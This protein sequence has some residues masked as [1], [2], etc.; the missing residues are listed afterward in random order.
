MITLEQALGV[1]IGND[2][3]DPVDHVSNERKD[4]EVVAHVGPGEHYMRG[5]ALHLHF[6]WGLADRPVDTKEFCARFH[7]LFMHVEGHCPTAGASER[8]AG[9]RPPVVKDENGA[10]LVEDVEF[11]EAPQRVTA[12]V[13]SMV[14]LRVLDRCKCLRSDQGG[15]SLA[16]PVAVKLGRFLKDWEV[17]GSG[18][19][20]GQRPPCPCD[21]IEQM[22]QRRSQLVEHVAEDDPP[23]SRWFQGV[24]GCRDY[25]LP[26]T[27]VM[28]PNRL[29]GR[30]RPVT[31]EDSVLERRC[32]AW[33]SGSRP[34]WS[35]LV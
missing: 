11:V 1:E 22:I 5:E 9:H 2:P 21:G 35:L 28:E 13:G 3:C 7:R 6:R 4:P 8:A 25:A 34:R 27:V 30:Y 31:A 16:D 29:S 24:M 10:V 32:S 33:P 12:R 18:L 15:Q 19:I 20:L 14:W 26:I 17:D 23:L